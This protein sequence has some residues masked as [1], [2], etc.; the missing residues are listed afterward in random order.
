MVM[1]DV[2]RKGFV[3]SMI[4]I[5]LLLVFF[6]IVQAGLVNTSNESRDFATA[7]QLVTQIEDSAIPIITR[8]VL[9]S[10]LAALIDSYNATNPVVLS[11]DEA[12]RLTQLEALFFNGTLPNG[13][14]LGYNLS[15]YFDQYVDLVL[16]ET[17]FELSIVPHN[18]SF[19]VS[20]SNPWAL[21]VSILY[22]YSL[23]TPKL[24][25]ANKSLYHTQSIDI[26]GYDDP[27]M[28]LQLIPDSINKSVS[29]VP[30]NVSVGNFTL[31]NM[32]DAVLQSRFMHN[33]ASPDFLSRLSNLTTP[34][35]FGIERVISFAMTNSSEKNATYV[36]HVFYESLGVC[37]N[38]LFEIDLGGG[39][40]ILLD[41]VRVLHYFEPITRT[42]ILNS[43]QYCP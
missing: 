5:L 6:I 43:S 2:S 30:A 27:L 4:A 8:A 24:E 10:H 41:N 1:C 9:R 25:W 12:I 19:S 29:I 7:S 38:P 33:N 40:T 16:N 23:R 21:D 28:Y 32:S 26:T 31:A 35:V 14:D 22:L 39:E 37:N 11:Q 13:Y 34:S 15:F 42:A 36:S 3:F 17:P 18:F 20:H